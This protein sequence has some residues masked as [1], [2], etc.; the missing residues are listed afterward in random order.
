[1]GGE[2]MIWWILLLPLLGAGI[3]TLL[4][5]AN[6][7]GN[8]PTAGN[9]K[10]SAF[11]GVL[12]IVLAFLIGVTITQKVVPNDFSTV[13]AFPW[14]EI[15]G[16]NIPFELRIDSLSMTMVLII[17]GIGAL[18]HLYA[19]G[20]MAQEKDFPRFFAYLNLFVAAMLMLVLGNNLLLLF[21][22]WEGVGL[23]SYLLIGFWY[24]DLANAKA[25]NKAFI[26]NRI[27]DWG[28]TLALFLLVALLANMRSSRARL[29]C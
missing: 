16:L 25:A 5:V 19:T 18:I 29:G 26:V 6:K 20:Y 4:S 17:T 10:L 15:A 27:G 2:K 11:L 14:I 3:Q 28:L 1:M 13:T 8:G 21:I 7:S 9:R 12:P 23:C 22:G 24:K